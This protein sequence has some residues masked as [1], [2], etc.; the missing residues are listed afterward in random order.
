MAAATTSLLSLCCSAALADSDA[1]GA[2]SGSPGVLSG[3]NVQVPVSTPVNV[4]GNSVN[5]VGLLNPAFGNACANAGSGSSAGGGV[6]AQ[7]GAVDS[8]GVASGN[9][10]QVPVSAPVNVCGD[11]V[12]AV[13]ALNPAYGNSCANAGPASSATSSI[14]S[15]AGAPDVTPPVPSVDGGDASS[16]SRTDQGPKHPATSSSS[17][18]TSS[19]STSASTGTSGRVPQPDTHVVTP[20]GTVDEPAISESGQ[21]LAQTGSENLVGASAASAALIAGGSMILYRRRRATWRR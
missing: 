12:N 1:N 11:S 14:P 10:V 4:C 15:Q 19:S 18:S 13:A 2:A 9:N 16:V 17:A 21:T 7:S 5:V 8:P 6:P 3:N 20:D